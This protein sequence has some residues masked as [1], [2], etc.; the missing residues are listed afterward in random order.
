MAGVVLC[1]ILKATPVPVVGLDVE[2][3]ALGAHAYLRT[4][5]A[6]EFKLQSPIVRQTFGV[7]KRTLAKKCAAKAGLPEYGVVGPEL[8]DRM[9]KAGAFQGRAGELLAA[10]AEANAPLI[11]PIQGFKALH[12]SLWRIYTIGRMMGLHDLGCYN[13]ASRLPGSGRPSDHAVY[14]AMAFDLGVDPDN[15]WDNLA[16]RRFFYECL[17]RPKDVEYVILGDRIAFTSDR[18]VRPYR[19]GGHLNHVHVSG[20]R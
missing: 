1:R 6:D 5:K 3:W 13:P 8:F 10:Y 4:G 9:L 14:P 17:D 18:N 20:H 15:G 2:G 12:Q 11:E 7:G 16:G 19:S